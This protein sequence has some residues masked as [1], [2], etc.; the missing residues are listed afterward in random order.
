MISVNIWHCIEW[1]PRRSTVFTSEESDKATYISEPSDSR[2]NNDY[3]G[4]LLLD[5][6]R[7]GIGVG[8]LLMY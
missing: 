8:L 6:G 4:L 7:Y 3:N 5:I 2:G 1:T